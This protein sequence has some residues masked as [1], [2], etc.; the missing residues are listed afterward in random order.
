[1]DVEKIRSMRNADPFRPFLL[2]LDDG[3]Q[4]LIDKPYYLAVSPKRDLLLVS[5]DGN[6]ASWF[7][8]TK[9]VEAVHANSAAA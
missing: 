5:T 7:S 2:A 9:V 6:G 4:F 3:R 8:P 1:M